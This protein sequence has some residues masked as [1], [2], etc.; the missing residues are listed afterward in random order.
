MVVRA[1]VVVLVVGT[2]PG[3]AGVLRQYNL[4]LD[5]LGCY[6]SWC[7][8][9]FCWFNLYWF[10]ACVWYLCVDPPPGGRRTCDGFV[11]CPVTKPGVDPC[12]AGLLVLVDYLVVEPFELFGLDLMVVRVLWLS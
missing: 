7:C 4:C 11:I 2:F 10:S 8:S 5:A 9:R 6:C 12:G 3:A 1:A